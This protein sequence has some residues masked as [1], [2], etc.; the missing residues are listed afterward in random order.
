M[1][2]CNPYGSSVRVLIGIG[3]GMGSHICELSNPKVFK[4]NGQG[5]TRM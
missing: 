5:M 2:F 3:I 1:G 4:Q